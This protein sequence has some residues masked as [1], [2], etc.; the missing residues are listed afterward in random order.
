MTAVDHLRVEPRCLA[1]E[2]LYNGVRSDM[3]LLNLG[4]RKSANWANEFAEWAITTLL[5][6]Q[7]EEIAFMCEPQRVEMKS[8]ISGSWHSTIPL[9]PESARHTG[10]VN[11]GDAV[12]DALAKM[13]TP[14]ERS[15]T[16]GGIAYCVRLGICAEGKTARV[17]PQYAVA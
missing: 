5:T 8:R 1:D 13:D 3:K 17:L 15:V 12:F 11:F 2:I 10:I 14:T 7:P 4:R 9:T 6:D 16:I